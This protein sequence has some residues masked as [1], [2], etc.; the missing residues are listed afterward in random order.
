MGPAQRAGLAATPP[1]TTDAEWALL[2]PLLP[3]PACQSP[4]GG[5]PE[6]HS[7]RAIVDAIRYITDNGS[8]WRALPADFPPWKT[9]HGFFTRW[10]AAGVIERIRDA[11]REQLRLRAGRDRYPSAAAIDSQ[12]VRAAETVGKPTRGYDGGKKVDGRKR[13][14][15]VDTLGLLLVVMV[16]AANS[17]DRPTG[18]LLLSRLRQT[19]RR[20]RHIW[21]DGGYN[22]TLADWAKTT[23]NMTVEIVKKP[24]R[25][26]TFIVLPRRWVVERTFSWISQ[27]RRNVRDYER[28][29]THSEAFIN[30]AM[31]TM[32]TRRLTHDPRRT[33]NP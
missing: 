27:A 21:A 13:H 16:T 18:R 3:V 7:R 31:I 26:K 8:K 25:A 14:I 33:T 30:W 20:V 19:Q 6:K 5:R 10:R 28:L 12:S 32:M 23:V 1:D 24:H 9:V 2:E 15:A 11:L 4:G 17:Q 29:P 22:G